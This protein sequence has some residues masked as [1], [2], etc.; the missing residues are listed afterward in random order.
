MRER[1]IHLTGNTVLDALKFALNAPA[2]A[3]VPEEAFALLTLHRRD[4]GT[5]G[6]AGLVSSV[7]AALDAVPEM[8]VVFPVHPS[9]RVREACETVLGNSRRFLLRPP[10][11]YRQF[12]QAMAR[13]RVVL[14]DS[15]G[16]QEEAALLGK[17]AVLL[18]DRTDR[19][20]RDSFLSGYTTDGVRASLT[21]AMATRRGPLKKFPSASPSRK[22]AALVAGES[23]A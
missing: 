11:G 13:A 6:F 2:P 22:I 4:L 1:D 17:P 12:V 10:M 15:G 14:T 3:D 21:K 8:P 9:P 16:I 18:R 23:C 19:Q 5:E 7:K 20:T